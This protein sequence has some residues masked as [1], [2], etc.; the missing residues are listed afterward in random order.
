MGEWIG[1]GVKILSVNHR[2]SDKG[3]SIL[4]QG[5]DTAPVE[6]GEDVWIGANTVILKGVKIGKGSIIGACSLVNK[7]IP[8]FSIAYGT[9]AK[10]ERK[11]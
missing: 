1:Y 7:D 6:I 10:V 11:R 8:P 3:K 5:Y 4:E 2:F 9:P